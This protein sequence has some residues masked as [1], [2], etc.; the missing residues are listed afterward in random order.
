MTYNVRT[1]MRAIVVPRYTTL[2]RLEFADIERPTPAPG[3][4]LVRVCATSINPYDRHGLRGEPRVARLMPGLMG[5]RGPGAPI[6]G[7]DVAGLVESVGPDVTTWRPGDDVYA[8]LPAG[9]FAEYVAVPANLLAPKPRNL[10]HAQ[11]A[12]IPMAGLTAR[13][14]L[15]Q[16]EPGH[17]VL[18]NGASG[19]T[20]TFAVQLAKALGAHV[21]AVTSATE[22]ARSLGADEVINYRTTDFTRGTERYDLLLDIAGTRRGSACRRVLTRDGTFV[23]VGGP[24]G[25]W[26]QPAGH[27]MAALAP[28]PLVSQR[29]IMA[30]TVGIPDKHAALTE[31][32]ALIEADKV[33]PVIDRSY[34]FTAI[35]DA[36]E[37][38]ETGH[39]RGKVVVEM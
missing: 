13:L 6:P 10:T 17:R 38:Q 21:T 35:R 20:G 34:P 25:R 11:T 8:L 1:T 27:I 30:D 5:L 32:N 26:F 2:D 37:Y 29:L 7:C 18:I 3:E 33:A 24:A 22:L 23:A 15:R 36:I 19:G 28:G 14:A 39:P 31:L 4:V 16:A 9:G 12:A